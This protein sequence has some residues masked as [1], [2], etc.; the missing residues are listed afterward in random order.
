MASRTECSGLGR[1]IRRAEFL[2]AAQTKQR[3][4]TPGLVL[5]V[6][7]RPSASANE[8]TATA[9]PEPLTRYGLTASRKVG[10]AVQRNRARR[11]LRALAREL[12]PAHAAPGND[13]VL[14]ARGATAGRRFADL[15]ADLIE[16]LRRTRAWRETPP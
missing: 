13:Y 11:R 4:S 15:R 7:R 8:P 5:Q 2:R 9:I 14:I 12:L 6:A 16:A 3:C 10:G 1:L